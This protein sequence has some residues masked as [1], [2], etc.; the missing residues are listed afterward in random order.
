[1]ADEIA[2]EQLEKLFK[3]NEKS[4]NILGILNLRIRGGEALPGDRKLVIVAQ[5]GINVNDFCKSF[6]TLS[7]K[8]D[9]AGIRL[10]VELVLYKDKKYDIIIKGEAFIDTLKRL[11]NIESFNKEIKITKEDFNRCIIASKEIRD[12]LSLDTDLED[13]TSQVQAS[14]KGVGVEIC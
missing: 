1:M 12:K 13:Y 9:L 7:K 5:K 8:L 14:L 10:S 2:K 11:L 4:S 3:D 6:N